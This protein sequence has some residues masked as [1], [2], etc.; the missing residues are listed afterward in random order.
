MIKILIELQGKTLTRH[1]LIE[2]ASLIPQ[3]SKPKQAQMFISRNLHALTKQDLLFAKGNIKQRTY[4]IS[5]ALNEVISSA[6]ESDSNLIN[7]NS[8]NEVRALLSEELKI[9]TELEIL[10]SEVE[11]YQKLHQRFPS[12]KAAISSLLNTGRAQS[13]AMYGRLNAIRNILKLTEAKSES[14]YYY[15]SKSHVTDFICKICKPIRKN[16]V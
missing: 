4:E 8:S 2:Q 12:K 14:Q 7:S 11:T 6:I 10:L 1:A 15:H 5:S 3:Y 9:A 16:E 13:A